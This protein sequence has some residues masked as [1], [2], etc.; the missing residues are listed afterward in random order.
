MGD[1]GVGPA[2]GWPKRGMLVSKEESREADAVTTLKGKACAPVP[3][4]ITGWSR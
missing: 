1:R 4:A 3:R 2:S